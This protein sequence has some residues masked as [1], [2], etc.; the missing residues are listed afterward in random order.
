MIGDGLHRT[1]WTMSERM[2][3]RLED[4]LRFRNATVTRCFRYTRL[5]ANAP[6]CTLRDNPC[7]VRGSD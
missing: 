2:R 6:K 3:A 4:R 7:I 5:A 1:T